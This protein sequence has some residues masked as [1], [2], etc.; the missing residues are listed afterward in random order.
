[1]HSDK[2]VYTQAVPE[3]ESELANAAV[4][5]VETFET[6]LFPVSGQGHKLEFGTPAIAVLQSANCSKIS[7]VFNVASKKYVDNSAR[8]RSARSESL[9]PRKSVSNS[10]CASDTWCLQTQ[11]RTAT[12]TAATKTPSRFQQQR[13][14]SLK[15][16]KVTDLDLDVYKNN[17]TPEDKT[18]SLKLAVTAITACHRMTRA[19][20][21]TL[22]GPL[23]TSC[24][25]LLTTELTRDDLHIKLLAAQTRLYSHFFDDGKL[26]RVDENTSS[27][28]H[29]LI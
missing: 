11:H 15:T 10:A 4:E 26:P 25:P 18:K 5:A 21:S 22:T 24:Q 19:A 14:Y 29:K 20:R 2:Y 7:P 6:P 23:S 8:L 17:L 1:M 9:K 16:A 13:L 12:A 28:R 27:L 3:T